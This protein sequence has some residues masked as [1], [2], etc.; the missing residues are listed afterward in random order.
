MILIFTN[1]KPFQYIVNYIDCF[2][3]LKV[4]NGYCF[5]SSII[6][7]SSTDVWEITYLINFE[8]VSH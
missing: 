6:Y 2:S 1:Q 7:E 8:P 5:Y 4:H 3:M